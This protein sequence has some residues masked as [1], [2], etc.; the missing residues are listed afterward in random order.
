VSMLGGTIAAK[1]DQLSDANV[2]FAYLANDLEDSFYY[3]RS[4]ITA[5][6]KIDVPVFVTDGWRDAFEAGNIRMFQA[7]ENRSVPT[8]L[9]IDPCTHKGCGGEYAPL[10]NPPN[11][12]N[13]EA[14]E[15]QFLD[16]Y[17]RGEDPPLLPKVRLYVQQ[18][19]RYVDA[20]SWPPPFDDFTKAYLG[21]GTISIR[22]PS[23]AT[24]SYLTNPTAGLSMSL[25]EEGTVAATPYIPLNQQLESD[26]G[27]SFETPVLSSPLTI[28]GPVA[29]HLVASS[30][31]DNTDWFVK[32]SDV[33]PNGVENIVSEGQL[34]ASLR[35]LA[36]SS[37]GIEPIETLD[38]PQPL[39]PGRFY[40]FEIALAPTA[41]Q[42]AAGDR[43]LVRITSDN[44]PN[45]L[46]ATVRFN[47]G[48]PLATELIPMPIAF[49]T[50]LLGGSD[51]TYLELPVSPNP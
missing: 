23:L 37:T 24:A 21:Q 7:L 27:V 35:Q 22:E 47:I 14:Q 10:T 39:L 25:D 20:T 38:D 3:E 12:D 15:F 5:V 42:F 11:P 44:L 18:L 50:V 49:N 48:D 41:Y 30:S 2:A 51:P 46:P 43:L 28:D 40:D 26:Q 33:A 17:L 32:I 1:L 6:S 16:R 45:A 8:F 19:D 4:P 9:H 29:I 36:P 34:R 31:A 13:L